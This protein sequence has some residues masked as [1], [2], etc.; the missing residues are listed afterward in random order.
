MYNLTALTDSGSVVDMVLAANSYTG[1]VL[2]P[3]FLVSVFFV[4]II[5]YSLK[6]DFVGGLT[7]SGWVCFVLSSLLVFADL[8]NILFPLG[9]LLLAAFGTFFLYTSR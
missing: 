7:V 6:F 9:F 2:M 8:I 5:S 1:D 3:L 4:L